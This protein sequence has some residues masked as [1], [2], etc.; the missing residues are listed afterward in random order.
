MRNLLVVLTGLMIVFVFAVS[1]SAGQS[2]QDIINRYINKKTKNGKKKISWASGS[3]SINRIN[4]NSDYNSFADYTS[5]HFSNGT[6]SWLNS[7]NSFGVDFGVIV[8]ERF[9]LSVGGEYWLKFGHNETGS[10]QYAP[11]DK[12]PGTIT[13]LKSEIT[14]VGGS[15]GVGYYIKN[16]PTPNEML[17]K[18]AL[19]V[20][21]TIGYYQA[22]WNIWP[23]YQNLNLSTSTYSN[24]NTTFMG[25]APGFSL[26]LGADYPLNF[27]DLAIGIDMSYLYLNFSNVAWYNTAD[28]E[29]VATYA[30]TQDA[31]VDLNFSGI[32]G[33]I[34][35]KKFFAW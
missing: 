7:V 9:A 6:V 33:K 16:T 17:A 35:V 12:A 21:G 27:G 30:D 10:F 26:G 1:G 3:F 4:R 22:K 2:E 15:I 19:R 13:N 23:E 14:V 20:N 29:V 18:L 25:T 32:R 31:R 24:A 11:P 28:Q 8:N 5:S 34:E